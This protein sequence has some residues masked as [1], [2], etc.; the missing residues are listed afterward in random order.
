MSLPLHHL[1]AILYG[2]AIFCAVVT[3]TWADGGNVLFAII[4]GPFIVSGSA[5]VILAIDLCLHRTVEWLGGWH[6]PERR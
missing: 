1:I 4:C 3:Y 5:F 2:F 6:S